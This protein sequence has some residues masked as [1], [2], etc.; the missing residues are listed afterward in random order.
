MSDPNNFVSATLSDKDQ[1]KALDLINQI[2]AI[3]PFIVALDAKSRRYLLRPGTQGLEAC[4][5]MCEAVQKFP[6]FFPPAVIDAEEMQRDLALITALK[7]IRQ[8]L[9]SLFTAVEDTENATASDL[10]RS[11][12]QSYGIAKSVQHLAPGLETYTEPAKKRLDKTRKT[13]TPTPNPEPK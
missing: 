8:A 5:S 11:T 10:Y 12:L 7:P 4:A 1:A 3:L 13:V 2:R 9:K 6:D